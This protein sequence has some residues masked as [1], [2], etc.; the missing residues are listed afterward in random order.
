MGQPQQRRRRK[1]FR[2][3][4]FENQLLIM[5]LVVAIVPLLG[6]SIFSMNNFRQFSYRAA[7]H[8]LESVTKSL[9]MLCEAQEALDRLKRGNDANVDAV[10][11]ASQLWRDGNELK[12]LRSIIKGIRVAERGYAFAFDGAGLVVSHPQFEGQNYNHLDEQS[13]KVFYQLRDMGK[14]LAPGEIATLEYLWPDTATHKLKLKV[15]KF[16]YFKPYDWII[17]VGAFENEIL[18]SYYSEQRFFLLILVATMLVVTVF[19]FV[20]SRL[21]MRPIKQ[22]TQA[23]ITIAQGDFEAELPSVGSKDDIGMLARSFKLMVTKVR[24]THQDLIEWSSTLEQ[25]VEQRTQQLKKAH[26]QML[27]TEKM[28]SLGKLS[29][30]VAHEINNPLSGILSYLKLSIKL[31]HKQPPPENVHD[32][33]IHYLDISA[34]EVKRVGD[35]VR[36]LLMFSKRSFGEFGYEHLNTVID[37]SIALIKHSLEM[38][39]MTLAKQLDEKGSDYLYCDPSGLQQMFIALSMNAIEAMSRG[40]KLSFGTD[41]QRPNE[42][43]LMVIDTG[44]GIPDDM[45]PHIFEPFFS[46]KSSEKSIGMGLSVVYGIVQSHGGTISV[47][48]KIGQGTAFTITLPRDKPAEAPPATAN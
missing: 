10:S 33:I 40:G 23:S 21:V 32:Q 17:G 6:Y 38:N 12:S 45:L 16:S 18:H 19:V 35:V 8:D 30:M 1:W 44:K 2:G 29:A 20:Q 47:E 42:V 25:K 48:S 15:S 9:I 24:N 11:G 13:R 34:T 31:L 46:S 22:L 7:M 39:G 37:K 14:K 26:E 4:K 5:A 27:M 28:A 3:L 43:R 41:Y 36:N